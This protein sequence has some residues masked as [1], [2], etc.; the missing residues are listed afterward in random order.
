MKFTSYKMNGLCTH[1]VL[2]IREWAIMTA[3]WQVRVTSASSLLVRSSANCAIIMLVSSKL[4]FLWNAMFHPVLYVKFLMI[5]PMGFHWPIKFSHFRWTRPLYLKIDNMSAKCILALPGSNCSN[6]SEQNTGTLFSTSLHMAGL[7][8]KLCRTRR[9]S[10]YRWV[11]CWVL[12]VLGSVC[13]WKPSKATEIHC[14][15]TTLVLL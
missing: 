3:P 9:L 15:A 10:P 7:F 8:R 5:H 11:G 1:L 2:R 13:N 4:M 12:I 6:K 14:Y